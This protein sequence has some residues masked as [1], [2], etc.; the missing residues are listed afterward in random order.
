MTKQAAPTLE[1]E[2]H[3]VFGSVTALSGVSLQ[4]GQ[5]EIVGL[6]GVNG[7]GKSTLMNIDGVFPQTRVRSS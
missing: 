1:V 4:A 6:I 2:D 5:G 7:A 3:H